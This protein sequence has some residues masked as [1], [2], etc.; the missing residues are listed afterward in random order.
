[1][2]EPR[3]VVGVP[4]F[5]DERYL[6]ETVASVRRQS[7]VHWRLI[8]VDDGSIDGSAGIA[9]ALAAGDSRI[10]VITQVNAG[11][12]AARNTIVQALPADCEFVMFLDH[13]D[14]LHP[15]ALELLLGALRTDERLG[16]AFVGAHGIARN[17]DADGAPYH[18]G[19]CEA[20]CRARAHVADRQVRSAHPDE[21]TTFR[22]LAFGQ[23]IPT[24]GACLLKREALTAAGPWDPAIRGADDYDMYLRLTNQGPMAFVDQVVIDYRWHGENTSNDLHLMHVGYVASKRKAIRSAA[25]TSANRR[26]LRQSFQ[27]TARQWARRDLGFV[28]EYLRQR[29]LRPAARTAARGVRD[30]AWS[31]WG[32]R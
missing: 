7:F 31:V 13:D 16:E 8:L 18:P 9:A 11:V 28:P 15:D 20:W 10:T 26:V 1:M 25:T 5:N 22:H 17:I 30:L 2:R 32:L 27:H 19:E 23:C 6:G 12:A 4:I 3:V 24:T 29:Q 21:P 14:V